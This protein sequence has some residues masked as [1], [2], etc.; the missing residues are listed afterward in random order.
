ML[1]YFS[2]LIPVITVI[3]LLTY[4]N[5]KVAWWEVGV[6]LGV[7]ILL[8]LAFKV[9]G[10]QSLI[11]TTE[12][13]NSYG[14]RAEY[15]EAW[16]EEVP[17]RHP[18][19][20]TET[21]TDGEGNTQTRQVLV[22]YMH[23]YDVDDHSPYWEVNGSCGECFR[24]PQSKFDELCNR[25]HN[26]TFQDLHRDYHS[27][28]GDMYYTVWDSTFPTIEPMAT[29]HQYKNKVKNS[30]SVFQFKKINPKEVK[31]YNYNGIQDQ[32][33]CDYIYAAGHQNEQ[34][35]LRQWNAL[36][37]AKKKV[38]FMLIP[39]YN[40]PYTACLDQEAYWKGGNKNEFILCVGVSSMTI[41]WAHVI[42]WTPQYTLKA[43]VERE[44][45]DMKKFD[46]RK[47]INYLGATIQ[48]HPTFIRRDFE[49]FNYINVPV[50]TWAIIVAYIVSLISSICLGIWAEENEFENEG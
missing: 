25:W 28:D 49:E 1:I 12:Y 21:Y 33:T 34:I 22:G 35:L 42:S 6:V 48:K 5:K 39:Y 17:C 27:K 32:Y 31:V 13:W 10:Q 8:T 41:S 43:K 9:I 19:Y 3:I 37:G 7:P 18:I 47:I 44:V 20:E 29:M 24:I 45:K 15:Y 4:F 14:T 30:D 16:D 36:L 23:A 38:V 11:Y 40:Q 2:W 26:K 46:C 50:P